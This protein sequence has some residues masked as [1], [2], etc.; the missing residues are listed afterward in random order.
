M[1]IRPRSRVT[2]RSMPSSPG[3]VQ[4]HRAFLGRETLPKTPAGCPREPGQPFFPG[5]SGCGSPAGSGS[6]CAVNTLEFDRRTVHGKLLP[7]RH[8]NRLSPFSRGEVSADRDRLQLGGFW[9]GRP[10]VRPWACPAL[11]CQSGAEVSVAAA[12]YRPSASRPV[13]R[14]AALRRAASPSATWPGAARIRGDDQDD[15]D[16]GCGPRRSG[17]AGYGRAA[18]L[19]KRRPPDRGPER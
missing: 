8:S 16:A 3:R 4:Y 14:A 18:F 15:K 6:I 11:V 5:R 9:V 17:S 12:G 19:T 1:T 13:P 7:S 10:Q 2:S